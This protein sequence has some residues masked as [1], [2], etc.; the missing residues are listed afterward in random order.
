MTRSVSISLPLG[1]SPASRTGRHCEG[2]CIARRGGTPLH[3]IQRERCHAVAAT[4]IRRCPTE[5]GCVTPSA[6]Q[7]SETSIV[8]RG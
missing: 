8:I 3:D 2:S 5:A 6:C 7:G 1:Q 4:S